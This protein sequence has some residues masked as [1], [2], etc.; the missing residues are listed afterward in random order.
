[1]TSLRYGRNSPIYYVG[2][3]MTTL[4]WLDNNLTL[5]FYFYEYLTNVYKRG[6]IEMHLKFCDFIHKDK[7]FGQQMRQGNLS[8]PCPYPPGEYHLYNMSIN[9][10][11]IPRNFPFIK[12]R[13][14]C[15]VT[16]KKTDLVVSGYIDMEVKEFQ[17]VGVNTRTRVTRLAP[18]SPPLR[19]G[20]ETL[21]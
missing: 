20:M 17:C 12:G 21:L 13:I 5:D 3:N 6:F 9:P 14:Y 11:A 18:P 10:E 16:Y 8:K 7:F 19:G 2:I 15:N 4:F 1:M